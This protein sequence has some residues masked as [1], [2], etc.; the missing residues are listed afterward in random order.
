MLKAPDAPCGAFRLDADTALVEVL[1]HRGQYVTP[2][3][4]LLVVVDADCPP[5]FALVE[6]FSLLHGLTLV[7]VAQFALDGVV[8]FLT[9]S[10]GVI[11]SQPSRSDGLWGQDG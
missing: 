10:D 7:V 11:A 1:N 5:R 2:S 4:W 9:Q 3:C 6:L 8:V